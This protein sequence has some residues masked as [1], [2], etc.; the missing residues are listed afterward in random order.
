[1]NPDRIFL[2]A[3]ILFSIA[4]GS[5]GLNRLWKFA[6]KKRCLLFASDYVVEE[7]RRNLIHPEQMEK[8]EAYLSN[9]QIIP[10]VDPQIPCPI[11]LPE[12]DQPVLLSAISIKANYLI[13]GDTIH[14]GKYFGKT[15][16]G[17]KICRPRDY[18]SSPRP[19]VKRG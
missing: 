14:F 2:D 8:L 5:P 7:A 17:V 13:T 19:K 11:E 15:V 10:E 6:K 4:Y 16:N 3:N 9:I 12:K 1:M 18:F